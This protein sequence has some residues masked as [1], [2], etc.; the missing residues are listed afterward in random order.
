MTHPTGPDTRTAVDIGLPLPIGV[1]ATLGN[2]IDAA[3]PGAVI[4]TTA[5]PGVMRL[6]LPTA[7]RSGKRLSRKAAAAHVVPSSDDD[8]QV[9]GWGPTDD[10]VQATFSAPQTLAATLLPLVKETLDDTDGAVNYIEQTLTDA[11]AP[12]RQYVVIAC[13]SAQQTPHALRQRAEQQRDAALALADDL[14]RAHEH[15]TPGDEQ[16]QI[17]RAHV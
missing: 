5:G 15:H 8:P 11:S 2:L 16:A 7:A 10:G 12:D 13:R 4:D 17:G 1:A 3:Y 6:L 14:L 9:L